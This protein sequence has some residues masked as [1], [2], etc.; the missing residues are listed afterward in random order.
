M[1]TD[2]AL[3]RS[4]DRNRLLDRDD[5]ESLG[6]WQRPRPLGLRRSGTHGERFHEESVDEDQ[7]NVAVPFLRIAA[8]ASDE[9]LSDR[10][11]FAHA[12]HE[13]GDFEA[14]TW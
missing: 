13:T 5:R 1:R 8:A 10:V 9:P 4:K 6:R 12:L 7:F 14:S 2:L 3:V 11:A